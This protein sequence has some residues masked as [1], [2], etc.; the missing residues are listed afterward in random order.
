[1]DLNTALR[2]VS[3]NGLSLRRCPAEFQDH[4][5][6]VMAAVAID[7]RAL[8][9]ASERLRRD[10]A[11][12]A[13]AV[14]QNGVSLRHASAELRCDPDIVCLH[15][16]AL[17]HCSEELQKELRLCE[18]KESTIL[19]AGLG[20]FARKHLPAGAVVTKYQGSVLTLREY[21]Q[22]VVSNDLRTH[23]VIAISETEQLVPDALNVFPSHACG[24]M[25]NDGHCMTLEA[26][27]ADLIRYKATMERDNNA[28]FDKEQR[29]IVAVRDIEAGD[30]VF[31]SY[32]Y[33]YWASRI[34]SEKLYWDLG[35]GAGDKEA[36]VRARDCYEMAMKHKPEASLLP[37]LPP[38]FSLDKTTTLLVRWPD[39]P[40][41][42]DS[43]VFLAGL[44][45]FKRDPTLLKLKPLHVRRL[46]LAVAK[47]GEQCV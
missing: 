8:Q 12:V 22:L 38:L 35:I 18:V 6:V 20:V 34:Y 5:D 47:A 15:S 31:I 23:Y 2:K 25:V 41:L 37:P 10:R 29:A 39:G 9:Y 30:E 4:F 26:Y 19:G 44:A 3:H 17:D 27:E 42:D 45:Q 1:M 43:E 7:G 46:L 32:G 21:I 28:R 33:A 40:E 24:H 11:V 13:A 16:A 36:L 14:T